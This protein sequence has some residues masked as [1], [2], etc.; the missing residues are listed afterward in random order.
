MIT[1][2]Q[3]L[4]ENKRFLFA[5]SV[6][7][8]AAY[9]IV[10]SAA[11]P[12]GGYTPGA[13]LNPNCAPGDTDCSIRQAWQQNTVD[14]FVYNDTDMVGIG[15]DAPEYTLDVVG[16]FNVETI[17]T[18]GEMISQRQ[19][20]LAFI[21]GDQGI[22]WYSGD[23]TFGNFIFAAL[24]YQSGNP[25][26][27][28]YVTDTTN[29]ANFQIESTHSSLVVDGDVELE[30]NGGAVDL[31]ADTGVNLN[32]RL[33]LSPGG[34]LSIDTRL[35]STRNSSINFDDQG[36]IN[37]YTQGSSM[38]NANL[39]LQTADPFYSNTP[40][41]K[42]YA[43]SNG[44]TTYSNITSASDSAG[45]FIKTSSSENGGNG[46]PLVIQV[47]DENT[48]GG[49]FSARSRNLT[50]ANAGADMF[51]WDSALGGDRTWIWMDETKIDSGLMLTPAFPGAANYTTNN[52]NEISFQFHNGDN[53]NYSRFAINNDFDWSNSLG[54]VMFIDGDT[55]YLHV[56]ASLGLPTPD[57]LLDVNENRASAY[58]ASFF[59]DGDNL[60][61]YGVLISSGQDSG[62]GT[63]IQ[64]NDGD[65]TSVGSITFSGTTTTYGTS[66]DRRL[67]D[68]I[69]D[70]R[71]TLQ[72][73]LNI[74]VHDYTFIAEGTG[75]VHTGF[76]A[77]ELYDIFPEA[78]FAPADGRMWSV[79]YGKISPLLVKAIQELDVKIAGV[80]SL[81]AQNTAAISSFKSML[82]DAGNGITRI[83]TDRLDTKQLCVED[84]CVT[85]D[86]FLLM[87]QQVGGQAQVIVPVDPAP[88]VEEPEEETEI[89]APEQPTEETPAP[90]EETVTETPPQEEVIVETPVVESAPVSE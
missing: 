81:V 24:D 90:Q 82:A 36:Q 64:F 32:S 88:V 60:N 23:Q 80:S 8:I 56:G 46:T 1:R 27:N 14:G 71:Y 12:T 4:L 26:Y 44:G 37:L 29:D 18:V 50:Y 57:Y 72:D 53:P 10:V 6:F 70:S 48:R 33:V 31:F 66:S 83:F 52:V 42:L 30:S 43:T 7:S 17:P 73:V 67:K 16:T 55:G 38:A 19:G 47:G 34:E 77:Q 13:T 40:T 79:D 51:V 49:G 5:I 3:K 2:F 62:D 21:G 84:V 25:I 87:V 11:A 22:V 89:V 65:G 45:M 39:N 41:V 9:S 54:S 59:N 20:D 68:N 58:A 35:S 86:Q 74:K 15:V 78:V 75:K 28:L 69:T 76:I 63:L 61:R 85:R